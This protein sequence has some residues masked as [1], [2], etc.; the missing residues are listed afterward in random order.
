M[1]QH[2]DPCKPGPHLAKHKYAGVPVNRNILPIRQC[3]LHRYV[4][5]AATVERAIAV[6]S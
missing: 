6:P 2:D 1:L 3:K 5:P 4:G